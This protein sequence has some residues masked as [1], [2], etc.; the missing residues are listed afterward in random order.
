MGFMTTGNYCIIGYEL[1]GFKDG[2]YP[3]WKNQ[4]WTEPDIKQASAIIH[5]LYMDENFVK[6]AMKSKYTICTRHSY[7]AL[8]KIRDWLCIIKSELNERVA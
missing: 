3:F 2:A 4:K 5:K 6:K 7:K 1:I 8:E